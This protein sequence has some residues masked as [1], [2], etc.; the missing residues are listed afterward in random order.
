M[1]DR[2]LWTH[3]EAKWKPRNFQAAH[4]MFPA[5]GLH[6]PPP[7]P[8]I[9]V[10]EQRRAA[11]EERKRKAEI[12]AKNIADHQADI[13]L[14]QKQDRENQRQRKK[15]KKPNH[16]WLAR[17]LRRAAKLQGKPAPTNE[18]LKAARQAYAEG[19]LVLA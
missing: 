10:F 12:A 15:H 3:K 19:R 13:L 14:R 7:E 17:H 16:T 9:N 11:A 6:L 4:V 8:T 5:K 1:K 2:T 18:A